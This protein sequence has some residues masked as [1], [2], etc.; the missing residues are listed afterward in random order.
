VYRLE[1]ADYECLDHDERRT[2]THRF[3]RALRQ[4][5]ESFRLY[6]YL[7][8]RPAAVPAAAMSVHQSGS[9]A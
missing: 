6:Q 2:I 3:E 5:D 7:I 8:K 1:G 4:L 9:V